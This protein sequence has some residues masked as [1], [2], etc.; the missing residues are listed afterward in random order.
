MPFSSLP[1][2]DMVGPDRS[3]IFF[4]AISTMR[5]EYDLVLAENRVLRES[6]MRSGSP[7]DPTAS[8]TSI[9]V[10]RSATQDSTPRQNSGNVQKALSASSQDQE[11]METNKPTPRPR[12]NSVFP[13][14]QSVRNSIETTILEGPK[15]G[16]FTRDSTCRRI[17]LHPH[18]QTLD[19]VMI[20]FYA[21][22]MGID[23]DLNTELLITDA[24]AV[25]Q[26]A[27]QLFCV[28]FVVEF[29]IRYFAFEKCWDRL[30]DPWFVLDSFL[31][32]LTV[33]DTW[34]MTVISLTSNVQHDDAA[35]VRRSEIIRLF[36]ILRLTRLGRV[37][38][39]V[40]FFPELQ[41]LIKA[42]VTA[43]RAVFFALLL[44][45][46]SHY[47]LAIG[48]HVT[49]QGQV[50]GT[51]MFGSVVASMQTLFV[52][53]TLLDEVYQLVNELWKEKLW[54]H[55]FSVYCVMF[56][57]AITLM[58]ILVGIVVEVISTVAMA[59]RESVKVQWVSDIICQFMGDADRIQRSELVAI[60][61][62]Q[63][64]MS[65]LKLIGVDAETLM[66][67]V[68]ACFKDS[69]S[70]KSGLEPTMSFEE[71][72]EVVL[73][74]RGS[75]TAT[76]K[77]VVELRKMIRGMQKDMVRLQE[78][79]LKNSRPITDQ[80]EGGGYLVKWQ[81]SGT[82]SESSRNVV[83]VNNVVPTETGHG[84]CCTWDGSP[85]GKDF[86]EGTSAASL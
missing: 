86:Q 47:T 70:A 52:H 71:F 12:R 74:L 28:Y 2:F 45:L 8:M 3:A 75:N 80:P 63:H 65:S 38:K 57:N 39:L 79:A 4:D 50:V 51:E 40:R 1:S 61:C 20:I 11:Q 60:L 82:G 84:S 37:V 85:Y 18:F 64:A 76:V 35:F 23:A 15:E 42:I 10:Q 25:C 6:Q 44:L 36:R 7:P 24:Q 46:A 69:R 30:R 29:C 55:L 48:F 9:D 33:F 13:S 78:Q 53:C 73:G 54:F 68:D 49:L 31:V 27:D 19:M 83:E 67:T 32:P 17:A 5:A 62:G 41:I 59:E 66:E 14:H 77:D 22:W 16:R 26:T 43:F 58:N 81:E 21:V 72:L 56:I 34:A